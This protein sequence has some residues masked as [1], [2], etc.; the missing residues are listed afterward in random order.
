MPKEEAVFVGKIQ[1]TDDKLG[2]PPANHDDGDCAIAT[3]DV[4]AVSHVELLLR[5]KALLGTR[6]TFRTSGRFS[7]RI[8]PGQ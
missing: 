4:E 7:Q 8:T 1:E 2:V 5:I 6:A 3:D